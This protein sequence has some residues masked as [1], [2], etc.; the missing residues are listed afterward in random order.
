MAVLEILEFPDPRLRT[1]AKP[2]DR[3]TDATRRLIDDMGGEI[4]VRNS[5]AGAVFEIGFRPSPAAT[6]DTAMADAKAPRVTG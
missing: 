4:S 3:V 1:K 5:G 6:E 2:V